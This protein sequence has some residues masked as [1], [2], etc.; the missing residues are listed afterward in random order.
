MYLNGENFELIG[1]VSFGIGCGQ[2][3]AVYA[4]VR[5]KLDHNIL[6]KVIL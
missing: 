5:G 3:P 6:F 1:I 2:A 4:K